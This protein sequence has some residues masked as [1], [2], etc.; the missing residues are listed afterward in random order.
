M[1]TI[2]FFDRLRLVF[3]GAGNSDIQSSICRKAPVHALLQ[4]QQLGLGFGPRVFG[5]D[6]AGPGQTD[7]EVPAPPVR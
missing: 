4:G 5:L 6:P 3:A 1:F 7:L 2:V